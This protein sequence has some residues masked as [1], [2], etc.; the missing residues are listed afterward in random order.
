MNN[1]SAAKDKVVN[2]VSGMNMNK[3]GLDNA[4]YFDQT[5]KLED[6]RKNLESDSDKEKLDAM[7]KLMAMTS[8][9]RDVSSL[10][11]HVVK[12]VISK[13]IELKKMVYM[14][15]VH[16]AE[17]EQDAALLAINSFQKD[18][19]NS[20]QLIRAF[21]L[22]VMSSIRVKIISQLIVLAIDK[23]CKDS[24]PYV[25][26]TAAHA[27]PK[28]Y[29]LDREQKDQCIKIIQILLTDRTTTVL[30]STITAFDEVCP[31]RFDLIHP[32]Y[33]KLCML[34]ADID[35]WGQCAILNMLLR[36]GRTQFTD[37]NKIIPKEPKPVKEPKLKT[38]EEDS[39]EEESEEEEESDDDDFGDMQELDP[40]H[41][42][43]LNS[44]LPLL[45]SRNT[46]VR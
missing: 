42:L 36:Y 32:H 30:G 21:A 45:K 39:E 22:R 24:S 8:K 4:N 25:R 38:G 12:S 44:A 23:S 18:L 1:L 34:L 3:M 35:E 11:P 46:A 16:Y 9:G 6:L 10:F 17:M 41:R 40:D 14:F 20:N 2:A 5:A 7:R 19:G 28:V 15:L 33:R 27:I 37:P 29:N 26:K 31:D 13:N 43:L